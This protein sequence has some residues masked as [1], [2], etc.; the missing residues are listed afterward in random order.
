[1]K[2]IQK[3]KNNIKGITIISLV[4]TVI[5]LIILAGIT[6]N[7]SLNNG[8]L[9]RTTETKEKTDKQTAVEKMN[10]KI[11]NSQIK[12]YAKEQRMPSLQEIADDLC[13]DNEIQY[14][15]TK[16]QVAGIDKI[17][18]GNASSIFTK[19]NQYPYE[20]EI[21]SSLQLASIDGQNIIKPAEVTNDELLV[22]GKPIVV[23]TTTTWKKLNIDF[24]I[25]SISEYKYILFTYGTS[26][27]QG[28]LLSRTTTL[29]PIDD[30]IYGTYGYILLAATDGSQY[31]TIGVY[32]ID[33]HTIRIGDV[34]A[35]NSGRTN[36]AI[37][38]IKGIK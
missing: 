4:I 36:F 9:T 2:I 8:I 27:E 6:I 33:D 20:F 19:L 32:V 3:S 26:D 18:V 24:N 29:Y 1:M 7:L 34:G 17:V 22:D 5:I 38:S 23:K 11:S 30:S 12:S 21:N 16:S 35:S 10:L 37:T 25:N 14:V 31:S 13:E 15:V 28:K